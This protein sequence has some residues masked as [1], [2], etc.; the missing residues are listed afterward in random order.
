MPKGSKNAHTEKQ[1]RHAKRIEQG[2][3]Q[4]GMPPRDAKR[5]ARATENKRSGGGSKGKSRH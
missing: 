2:H 3:G 5:V 1:K 4:R